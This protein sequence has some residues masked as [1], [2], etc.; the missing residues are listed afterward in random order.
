MFSAF[1]VHQRIYSVDR[2]SSQRMYSRFCMMEIPDL[3]TM[4]ILS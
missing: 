1:R 2:F 4:G 3:F